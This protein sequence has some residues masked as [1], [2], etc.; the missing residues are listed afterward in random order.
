MILHFH[1]FL[2]KSVCMHRNQVNDIKI[3]KIC[4]I[5]LES[6][7][8]TGVVF[9]DIPL[10]LVMDICELCNCIWWLLPRLSSIARHSKWNVFLERRLLNNGWKPCVALKSAS[11][12]IATYNSTSKSYFDTSIYYYYIKLS[13]QKAENS[14][15]AYSRKLIL[16]H[17]LR[18]VI[19]L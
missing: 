18:S 9:L 13:L 2:C 6:W 17:P 3:Y 19:Y 8:L 7:N 16:S 14:C 12:G 1:S 10:S 11:V 5:C 4:T 15:H